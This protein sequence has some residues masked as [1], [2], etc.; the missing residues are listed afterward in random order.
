M[1]SPRISVVVPVRD[2]APFLGLCLEALARQDVQPHEVLVV[3]N[4]SSRETALVA[5]AAGA[6]VVPQEMPGIAAAAARGYDLATGDLIARLDADSLPP[7]NWLREIRGAFA[8]DPALAAVTGR[9]V[10]ADLSPAR[11]IV[12]SAGYHGVYYGFFG[13]ALG[14]IPLHGSNFAMRRAVWEEVRA[15]VHRTDPSVHDDL[16]LTMRLGRTRRVRF[17][18]RLAVAVSTRAISSAPRL[19]AAL[20]RTGHTMRMNA[21]RLRETRAGRLVGAGFGIGPLGRLLPKRFHP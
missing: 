4:G 11:R 3:D 13:I 16:D 5:R 2:E 9:G 18:P 12:A 14:Q 17:E 8:V 10:F 20:G 15:E 7:M 1:T 6:I 21:D 19:A